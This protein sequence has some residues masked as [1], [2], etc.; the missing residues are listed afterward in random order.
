M[1]Q[2]GRG[3]WSQ[4]DRSR[5][6]V[7]CSRSPPIWPG[8]LCRWVYGA[9]YRSSNPIRHRVCVLSRL[10]G[11]L[12]RH[13][14]SPVVQ[15]VIAKDWWWTIIAPKTWLIP[16]GISPGDNSCCPKLFLIY[17][18]QNTNDKLCTLPH[19]VVRF[20]NR[21]QAR[22]NLTDCSQWVPCLS[23]CR[24]PCK[25]Y[26]LIQ[27]VE[28]YTRIL[29]ILISKTTIFFNCKLIKR[30]TVNIWKHLLNTQ[31]T[32]AENI[33]QI[34]NETWVRAGLCCSFDG[35]DFNPRHLVKKHPL[36]TRLTLSERSPKKHIFAPMTQMSGDKSLSS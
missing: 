32:S 33:V 3:K 34:E 11:L 23:A 16:W 22:N 17:I 12:G 18:G 31:N 6:G 29:T 10:R 28:S 9:R 25:G 20:S 36:L 14:V 15:I 24:L 7:R 30:K 27:T 35:G 13:R 1:R 2:G 8:L 4:R 21:S 26:A 19:D 5:Q